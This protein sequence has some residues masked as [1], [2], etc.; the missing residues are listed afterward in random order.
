M[1]PSLLF[2]QPFVAFQ[3]NMPTLA[4]VP[5]NLASRTFSLNHRYENAFVNEVF[6][7]NILLTLG[8]MKGE[9]KTKDQIVWDNVQKPFHYEF[10]LKPGEGFAFHD[11]ILPEYAK[12]VVRTTNA[13]FNYQDGFKSDGYLTGDGV[14]HLASLIYWVAKDAGL[15]TYATANHNFAVIP[16]VPKEYGVSI[17]ARAD[18]GEGAYSN[19]YIV[20][21]KQKP[22]K[23]VFDYSEDGNLSVSVRENNSFYLQ[24]LY[25]SPTISYS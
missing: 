15:E 19:L 21:N 9:V 3:A 13:H 2:I 25:F 17:Y 22:I 7:D 23:F 14:C 1:L 8:Y 5:V 12:K 16:D 4:P 10:L 20:N 24:D 11:K 6:K 18:T